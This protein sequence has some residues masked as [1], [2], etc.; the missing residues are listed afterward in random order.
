MTCAVAVGLKFSNS[1]LASLEVGW[2]R[3]PRLRSGRQSLL[4]ESCDAMVLMLPKEF[5][6]GRAEL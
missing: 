4:G 5:D 1:F 6:K 2:T 3:A